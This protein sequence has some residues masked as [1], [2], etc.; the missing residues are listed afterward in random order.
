MRVAIV[1][2]GA[3]GLLYGGWLQSAGVDVVFVTRPGRQ[4][5]LDGATLTAEGR[6]SF[7]LERVSVVGDVANGGSFDA[8]ILAVKLYDLAAAAAQALP[9]LAP[10][11]ALVAIQ[12]G[13]SA[14]GIL[15]P[16]LDPSRLAIGP[17]FAATRL[18]GSS[19]VAYAGADRVTLGNPE[20]KVSPGVDELVRRWTS[21]GVTA[22][23]A[24][25]IDDVIWTLRS[26][27]MPK[28]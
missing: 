18:T 21:V 1:G 16:L 24:E 27:A 25:D 11:G 7:R 15:R 17:V 20:C 28:R 26:P 8:I 3:I 23:I 2:S 22:E 19:S 9:A 6:L 12:N 5:A 4:A 14:Y 13:V 10:A